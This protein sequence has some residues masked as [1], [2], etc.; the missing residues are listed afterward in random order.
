MTLVFSSGTA[1]GG[2]NLR[3]Y[4]LNSHPEIAFSIDAFLPFFKYFRSRIINP[5]SWTRETIPEDWNAP[6]PDLFNN[7]DSLAQFERFCSDIHDINIPM[8]HWNF[9]HSEIESRSSLA[10]QKLVPKINLSTRSKFTQAIEEYSEIIA[11][12]Y[13]GGECRVVGFQENWISEFF[14]P[15]A[16]LF[17]QAKFISY[18]RDPRAVL[19]SSENHEPNVQK[20]P[21]VFSMARHIRKNAA[22]A[23]CYS[24]VNILA[25]RFIRTKYED[26]FT[27]LN[28]YLVDILDF[29]GMDFDE[30][31]L[32]FNNYTSGNGEKLTN[33]MSLYRD[34]VSNWTSECS[35][36]LI[37]VANY[38]NFWEMKKLGYLCDVDKPVRLTNEARKFLVT[39]MNSA[40]GWKEFQGDLEAQLNWENSR[41]SNF[42]LHYLPNMHYKPIS[43]IVNQLHV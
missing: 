27:N 10:S 34:A 14:I 36:I 17:P 15:L 4:T 3:T 11:E 24:E 29:L 13:G 22:L 28:D 35:Q 30:D 19:H 9:L 1:R 43:D 40:I 18:L 2:T 12:T 31:M 39:N 42:P 5:N 33:P 26:Y 23:I 6:L 25:K 20:H 41:I 16:R 8:T 21:A 37:E 38:L 32:N 7:H